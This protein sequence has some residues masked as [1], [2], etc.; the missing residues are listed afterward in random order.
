MLILRNII[1]TV[2]LLTLAAISVVG[3]MVEAPEIWNWIPARINALG[4]SVLT[5]MRPGMMLFLIWWLILLATLLVFFLTVVRPRK[6]MKIEVQMGGG[7]VVIMDAAIKKYI[8]NAL[9]E[10]GEVTVKKI[11]LNERRGLVTTDITADVRT[12]ENLPTLER[13]IISRVRAALAEDLGI[14]NLGDVHVFVR[15]FEVSG[16]A[17]TP[18]SSHSPVPSE[19]TAAEPVPAGRFAKPLEHGNL[20][21]KDSESDEQIS[22]SENLANLESPASAA[23]YESPSAVPDATPLASPVE[24]SDAAAAPIILSDTDSQSDKIEREHRSESSLFSASDAAIANPVLTETSDSQPLILPDGSSSVEST[25]APAPHHD[26]LD[27]PLPWEKIDA[28][29]KL[30]DDEKDFRSL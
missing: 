25:M 7:R 15:N 16:R 13:R 4:R 29:K 27:G 2:L 24:T 8:R 11:D 28:A 14:T 19:P 18:D 30:A 22:H 6:R 26:D 23:A 17:I 9:S 1:I 20:N 10:L 12:K 3:I 5:V 21:M